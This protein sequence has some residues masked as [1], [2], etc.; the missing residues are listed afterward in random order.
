MEGALPTEIKQRTLE[1]LGT[2]SFDGV[3]DGPVTA[4]PKFDVQ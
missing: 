3:I 2:H 1:T 4:H